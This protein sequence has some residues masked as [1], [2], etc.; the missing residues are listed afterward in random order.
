[1]LGDVNW[2][3]DIVPVTEGLLYGSRERLLLLDREGNA[4]AI[5]SMSI[6]GDESIHMYLQ[7]VANNG[8]GE[9]VFFGDLFDERDQSNTPFVTRLDFPKT[10]N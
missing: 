1:M 3:A 10:Y 4:K 6:I 2:G 9:V 7:G 5:D 8:N